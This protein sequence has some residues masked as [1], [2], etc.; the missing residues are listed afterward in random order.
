MSHE[1][2]EDGPGSILVSKGPCENPDCGSSDGCATYDDGH[3]FCF[4][5]EH[6]THG[7]GSGS[8]SG[9]ARKDTSRAAG[10]LVMSENEGRFADL[11]KR[12]LQA[13]ICRKY[14]YWVGRVNGK[15]VQVAD[16]K[17][18]HGNLEGQKIRD[19][20]KNFSTKGKM[21]PNCLFGKHLFA[22][23]KKIVLTEGEIDCLSVAQMQGGKYPV[24]SIP[25]GSKAARKAM[26]ANYEYLD[27]FDEIILMFDMDD[28]GR[29]AAQEA[30]EVLPPGKVKIAVLPL[31]DA[32]ECLLDRKA[33]DVLNAIW[34]ASPFIPDGVVSAK[35]MKD[36]VM[37]KK[38]IP[39]L[40]LSGPPEMRRMT[41]DARAGELLMVTSGSGMGKSTFVRQNVLNWFQTHNL[42][43]G[44]C[45]LEEAVEE[46]L[47][48]LVG[49]S[50]NVR[51][52]QN[53]DGTSDEAFGVA[54]DKLFEGDK[55]HLYDSFAES[56]ED[57][58]IAKMAYMVDGLGCK[59]IVLDHISIVVSGMDDLGDERK[60][61]DRLMTRLKTF[62]KTKD[63]LMVVICHL[64]N[65]EKGKAHE[66]GR[67]VSITDLRGSGSL[68]QLS[69]TIIAMER[70]QQ[71][72]WP[73]LV[74]I[75]ILKCRFTGETGIAGYLI[76]NTLTGWLDE[77]PDGWKP[78]ADGTAS[79]DEWAGQE[80][81]GD[82]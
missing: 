6:R 53:P 78:Q 43:T 13:D 54:F 18:E 69:D 63:I 46:T 22:N 75:R 79:P 82:Y 72:D 35:G 33:T 61:I 66:E 3:S 16:Y 41:K 77:Q 28:A 27:G 12:G 10:T 17:D 7:D 45:M 73:N 40:P 51:Y 30:A 26:A 57:R 34:N 21:G 52:R 56:L 70:N 44:V 60:T 76:Y 4:V 36:R 29:A 25:L 71:G 42:D 67:A 80:E 19:A 32:N 58:L 1:Y 55:L 24:V 65:P 8:H 20:D 47:Q 48:D 39:R 74:T 59:V 37:K 5:C 50:L 68:R 23:G 11:V 31:K 2:E 62:A 15:M 9:G 38:E 81:D 64:K 49:L 14:G